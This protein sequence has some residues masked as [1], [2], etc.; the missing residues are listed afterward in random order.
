MV[1]TSLSA[2]TLAF[3]YGAS[4]LKLAGHPRIG[5]MLS[6]FAPIGRMA[7]T[8]YISQSLIFG[9]VFFGYGLGYFGKLGATSAIT[10]GI[11]VYVFQVLFSMWWLGRYRYG[12]LEWLWRTL[13]YG[14][15]QPMLKFVEGGSITNV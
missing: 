2:V 1:M 4:A 12:P 3:G 7:F 15:R 14:K 10:F 6:A 8:T 13:M 9:F 11:M 5:P